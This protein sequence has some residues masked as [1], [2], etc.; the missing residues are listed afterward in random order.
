MEADFGLGRRTVVGIVGRVLK[1]CFHDRDAVARRDISETDAH[2]RRDG[3]HHAPGM[4]LRTI[5]SVP[6]RGRHD[7]RVRNSIREVNGGG[8]LL[9]DLNDDGSPPVHTLVNQCAV[10]AMHGRR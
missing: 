10:V 1:G 3:L 9:L 7:E 2:A 8:A 6:H 5:V 4:I